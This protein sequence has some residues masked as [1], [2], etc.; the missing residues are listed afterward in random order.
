MLDDL[1]TVGVLVKQ[2]LIA[3]EMRFVVLTGA[4]TPVK[5]AEVRLGEIADVKII[6]SLPLHLNFVSDVD[7]AQ[8]ILSHP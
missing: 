7:I 8:Y 6:L 4:L 3:Q 2:M 1:P 5:E